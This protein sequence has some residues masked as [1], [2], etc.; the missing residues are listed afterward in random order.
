[1]EAPKGAFGVCVRTRALCIY[2]MDLRDLT[3]ASLTRGREHSAP[4]LLVVVVAELDPCL[5]YDEDTKSS[6]AYVR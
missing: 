5:L 3:S 1:M 4:I 6:T 2:A